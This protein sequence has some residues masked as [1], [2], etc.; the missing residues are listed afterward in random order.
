MVI[1]P[2]KKRHLSAV[3]EIEQEVSSQP[4]TSGIFLSELAQ[5]ETR[6]YLVAR[7]GGM[8]V[9]YLGLFQAVD[10]AHVTNVGVAPAC[11][12]RGVGSRLL[13]AG[14]RA[15]ITRGCR[16]FTLEVR[17]GNTAAQALYRRFGFAPAGV[18]RA[19]YPDNREDA[20]IMWAEDIDGPGYARRLGEIEAELNIGSGRP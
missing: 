11:H 6:T 4:W 12:R 18:R 19:Y 13:V 20:L 15:A 7:V 17:V 2:M 3:L 10:D 5:P 1:E 9:G 14:A 8:V 16:N